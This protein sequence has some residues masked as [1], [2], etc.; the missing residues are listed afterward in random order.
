[1]VHV[2]QYRILGM[3][4]FAQAY[5]QGIVDSDFIYEKIPLEAI[6]FWMTSRFTA[7]E[8]VN[9]SAELPGWLRERGYLGRGG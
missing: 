3:R 9:V 5:V 4:E 2:E 1:M 7:R 8:G 6:A